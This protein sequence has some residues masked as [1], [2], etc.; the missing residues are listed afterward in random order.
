MSRTL[1]TLPVPAGVAVLGLLPVLA[2]ALAG[3]GPAWLPVPADDERETA[4]LV[5]ALAAGAPIQDG[6]ALV[7]ATSGST[8][9]PKGAMLPAGALLASADATHDR[10]GGAGSWLLA[11]A[12]H[13]VAGMQVLLRS[14]LAGTE[15]TVV[16]M[17]GGFDAAALVPA[18]AAMP[19]GR[20]YTSLVPT[21]LIRALQH[22]GATAALAELDAVMLGG[23]ATSPALLDK[24][25]QAGIRVVRT[26]G[27]SETSGGCVY[28]GVPLNGVDVR[29]SDGRVLL[30][31]S[32]LA[33]GYR[34]QPGHPAFSEPGWFRTDD[35]GTLADGV[36]SVLGR[37]DDA[38]TT[39][40][41]T[42]LPQVVEAALATHPG[43]RECAVIGVPDEQWGQ[44][45]VAVVVP[46]TPVP[47]L[48]ELR[49]YVAAT[50]GNAA[51]PKELHLVSELPLR[52]PGKVDR[53]ALAVAARNRLH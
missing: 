13:H 2:D 46:G 32:P 23:A 30:G 45:V 41:L 47:T 15:P 49:Q 11:L 31:G 10:L 1:H 18:V 16:T 35:A 12:A 50:A 43:V 24:A 37:L 42:V 26:Y 34:N 28:D 6:V 9:T 51:A 39:G 19:S 17:D 38:I 52:G 40:G 33:L 4:R 22:P 44:R 8:G 7:M 20:R 27:M 29:I 3:I 21:Q 48:A 14:V 53:R 36:L 25:E 5:D